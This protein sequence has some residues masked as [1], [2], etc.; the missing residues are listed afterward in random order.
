MIGTVRVFFPDFRD[1]FS[2]A[3]ISVIIGATTLINYL[4][5]E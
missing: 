2:I 3:I 1:Y 5:S 4:F